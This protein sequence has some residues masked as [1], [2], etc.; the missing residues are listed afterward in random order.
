MMEKLDRLHLEHPFLGSRKLA[1]LLGSPEEAVNRKRVVRLMRLMGLECLFPRPKCTV[2]SRCHKKYPY[3][4]K[5]VKID[6]P[7]QVWST[8]ITYVPMPSGFMYLAATIDWFSRL[9]V[10]WR[11]SNTLDGSFCQAMLEESLSR[12][13]PEIFNTDQGVQFTAAA[14]TSRLES[15]GIRVSMNGV[16]RCHDN[17][18][19]ERLWRSVKYEELYPK[20]YATVTEL[21]AG[22]TA[23]FRFYNEVRPHQSLSYRTPASVHAAG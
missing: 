13:C 5:G 6:R 7:G 3:L 1:V 2:A 16:G 15:D 17:I 4:L 9:V 10:S 11:L 23:Y 8:D 14:W 19:V 12:G 21:E 22:L 18:F 20:R